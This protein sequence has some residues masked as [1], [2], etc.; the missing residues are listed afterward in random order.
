MRRPLRTPTRTIA[1]GTVAA[2]A[3]LATALLAAVPAGAAPDAGAASWTVNLADPAAQS[4]GVAHTGG[5]L[6]LASDAYAPAA[7]GGTDRQGWTVLPAHTL[8]TAA[9]QVSVVTDATTPAGTTVT[10]EVRGGTA[11]G[12]WTEWRESAAGTPA[13]LPAAADRMQARIDLSAPASGRPVP[14][15]RKVTL[16]ADHDGRSQAAPAARLTAKV[17]ATREGLVGKKTANGHVIKSNDHF[18]ALPSGRALNPNDR[19]HDYEVKVCNPANKKCETAPVFDVGPWNTKD[20]YWNPSS[21]RQ[22]WK[23][24]KQGMPE[25]QAAYQKGYHGGKDQFGRKV[26]NPAGIDLAD[27]TFRNGLGLKDNGWVEVTYLWT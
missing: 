19:T 14:T 8:N 23:D 2:V 25:A 21:K 11:D 4:H 15:V 12:H 5:G 10:V 6:T 22:E 26:A 18:V 13:E 17:F 7:A 16:T 1:R 20:D 27:G 3:G 24:L 9:N